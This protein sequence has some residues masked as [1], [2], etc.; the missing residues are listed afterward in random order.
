MKQK[1]SKIFPRSFCYYL[2]SSRAHASVIKLFRGEEKAEKVE[3][4][5]ILTCLK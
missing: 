3:L 2:L 1:L 5:A 4:L